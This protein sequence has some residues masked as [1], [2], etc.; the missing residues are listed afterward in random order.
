MK[1]TFKNIEFKNFLSTGN[2]SININL[3]EHDKTLI[4]GSNGAGKS[5]LLDAIYFALFGKPFRKLKSKNQLINGT[6]K[7][8]LEVELELSKGNIDYKIIRGMKPNKLEFYKD[9]EK[10]DEAASV[11]DFQSIIED[12]IGLNETTFKQVIV[13]GT[14]G[15][16][17]FMELTTPQKRAFIEE[18]LDVSVYGQMNDINKQ[19]VKDIKNRMTSIESEIESLKREALA[20]KD[21]I[22]SY[23]KLNDENQRK[24]KAMYDEYV[25]TAKESKVKLSKLKEQYESLQEQY[26]SSFSQQLSKVNNDIRSIRQKMNSIKSDLEFFTDSGECPTCTQTIAPEL[27][28]SVKNDSEKEISE[29]NNELKKLDSSQS[30]LEEIVDKQNKLSEQIKD[31]RRD[32]ASLKNEIEQSVSKAK[33]VKSNM[34]VE[35]KTDDYRDKLNAVKEKIIEAKESKGELFEEQYARSLVAELLKDSG[36]KADVLNEYMPLINKKLNQYIKRTGWNCL[37]TLDSQFNETVQT[38]G[39][40]NFAYGSFSQG[41]KARIDVSLLFTWRDIAQTVSGV[42]I[43]LLVLDE[44]FDSAADSQGIEAIQGILNDI[45]GNIF[46]ISHRESHDTE[47]FDNHIHMV[48]QGRFSHRG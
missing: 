23:K 11:K 17:P 4:T 2:D 15:Y 27:I 37:I 44:V 21:H 34:E 33:K 31:I 22:D 18:L 41:E 30:E 10:V 32:M 43:N 40:Q 6:N 7:K 20:H 36:I 9:G 26:D 8:K 42:E 1:L 47:M 46:V 24:L 3:C 5:Q 12:T 19:A 39:K 16:T 29:Y 25:K 48:K 14:A 13:V 38:V 28:E 35:D 45:N